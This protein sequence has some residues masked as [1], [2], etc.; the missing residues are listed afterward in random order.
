M[1]ATPSSALQVSDVETFRGEVN[2]YEWQSNKAQ[3]YT[4]KRP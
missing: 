1:T 4:A 3:L 2:Q